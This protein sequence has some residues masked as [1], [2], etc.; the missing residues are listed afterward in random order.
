MHIADLGGEDAIS[1]SELN[2]GPEG[3]DVDPAA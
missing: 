1:Y 2:S 3:S